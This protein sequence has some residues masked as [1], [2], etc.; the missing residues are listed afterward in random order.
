MNKAI[1]DAIK[2]S[3]QEYWSATPTFLIEARASHECG[4]KEGYEWILSELA[5]NKEISENTLKKYMEK[6]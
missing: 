2:E 3:W 5:I 6:I 1:K 4:W